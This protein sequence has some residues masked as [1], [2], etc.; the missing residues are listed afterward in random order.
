MPRDD[1]RVDALGL[2]YNVPVRVT[3]RIY[4]LPVATLLIDGCRIE[5][6]TGDRIIEGTEVFEL[7]P[8][9][10]STQV[11]EMQIGNFEWLVHTK[12]IE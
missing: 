3:D 12:K 5:P 4:T 9:D 7:Q 1:R 8:P 10:D 2:E 6:R 11:S